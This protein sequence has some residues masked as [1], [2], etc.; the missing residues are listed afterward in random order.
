MLHYF[1]SEKVYRKGGSV[2]PKGTIA[3]VPS[4][5]LAVQD[6]AGA[7]KIQLINVG[8]TFT[9]IADSTVEME[10]WLYVRGA[11]PPAPAAP[12]PPAAAAAVAAAA[13]CVCLARRRFPAATPVSPRAR[14]SEPHL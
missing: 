5:R 12:P 7:R 3:L 4:T 1:A 11:L 13:S 9:L 14:E 8:R 2:R 6:G 10:M